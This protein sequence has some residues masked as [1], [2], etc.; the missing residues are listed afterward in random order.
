MN[1]KRSKSQDLIG[2]AR[3]VLSPFRNSGARN[4]SLYTP[5]E[6]Q[7][8]EIETLQRLVLH[9]DNISGTYYPTDLEDQSSPVRYVEDGA[10]AGDLPVPPEKFWHWYGLGVEAD[11]LNDGKK[12]AE[13]FKQTAKDYGFKFDSGKKVLDFGCSGGR[14]T[15]WFLEEASR[16]LDIWGCDIDA[17]AIEWCQK[18]LMPPFKFFTNTTSPHLPVKDGFF[19]FIFAGSVFTHIKDMSTSWVLELH[20]CMS[21][22]GIGVFTATT[23][24]SLPE[25][26]EIAKEDKQGTKKVPKYVND[27]NITESYLKE[28][29]FITIQSSPWWLAAIYHSDFFVRRLSLCFDVVSIVP[30]LKGYQ[31]GFVVKPKK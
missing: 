3:R 29:G 15:R 25:L 12:Q 24:K 27:N 31:T 22:D 2:K 20:R 18:N 11:Y 17:A 21:D 13:L 6:K 14:V 5:D 9:L 4:S 1:K 7:M 30:S 10:K 28:R 19:D 8:K 23:E 26:F 16:G